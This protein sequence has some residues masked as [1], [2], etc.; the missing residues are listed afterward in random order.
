MD[1]FESFGNDRMRRAV[2]GLCLCSLHCQHLWHVGYVA[3]SLAPLNRGSMEKDPRM[4]WA[5]KCS[6]L[7][8]VSMHSSP[9][10]HAWWS[11]LPLLCWGLCLSHFLIEGWLHGVPSPPSSLTSIT[12]SSLW[13]RFW[14]MVS[15]MNWSVGDWNWLVVVISELQS[16][17]LGVWR[18][19]NFCK[20][21]EGTA[22]HGELSIKA[23]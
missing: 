21:N 23:T 14:C 4:G 19:C 22:S 16:I 11:F 18:H 20:K 12:I 5:E 2:V 7:V 6:S 15:N 9:M 17:G 1:L 13:R 3:W 10:L 8:V